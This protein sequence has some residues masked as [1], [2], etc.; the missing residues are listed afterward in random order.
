[1]SSIRSAPQTAAPSE[2]RTLQC[3]S[4]LRCNKIASSIVAGRPRVA[5]H[6]GQGLYGTIPYGFPYLLPNDVSVK[7]PAV[8]GAATSRQPEAF[9]M[10]LPFFPADP[11]LADR[12]IKAHDDGVHRLGDARPATV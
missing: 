10:S 11:R 6:R 5:T 12:P 8:G 1:L 9:G 7:L 3:K 4:I 2:N